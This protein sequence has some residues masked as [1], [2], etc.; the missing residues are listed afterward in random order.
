MRILVAVSL[1]TDELFQYLPNFA[2][3]FGPQGMDPAGLHANYQLKQ[4]KWTYAFFGTDNLAVLY[5]LFW[6]WVGVTI[7]F[8]VGWQTRWMTLAVWF[9]TRCFIERNSQ[10]RTG[11]DDTLQVALFLI[12]LSPCGKALSFDA[13]LLR[14]KGLLSGPAWTPPWSLRL[15]QIQLCLI[16]GTTGL[17][18]LKGDQWLQGPMSNWLHGTWWDGTSVYYVFNLSDLSRWSYAQ[19]PV[20]LW[21]T[22]VL[23]Y[24]SVWWEAL[25]PLMMLH[26]WTR[27]F[28]LVFGVLFHLGI[29]LT[30]EVGWFGFYTLTFY[31]V[32][33]PDSFWRRFDKP[34]LIGPAQAANEKAQQSAA[35]V[36]DPAA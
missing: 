13:W 18:K 25:F 17:I 21:I 15:I 6:L 1:L 2:E 27:R 26:R 20:P 16:Y 14:R 8:L 9:L 7:L 12:L 31:G 36:G 3:F 35:V 30:V 22:M 4:W 32:W 33:T 29:Y 23:T 24:T 34:S 11:A 28:A 5:P 10:I 19:L